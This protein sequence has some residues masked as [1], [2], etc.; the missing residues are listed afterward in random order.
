MARI[1]D[2]SLVRSFIE[3][4]I[5]DAVWDHSTSSKNRKPKPTA[6]RPEPR[7]GMAF[8]P[9]FESNSLPGLPC[10]RAANSVMR[11]VLDAFRMRRT[12]MCALRMA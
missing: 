5:D 7:P 1:N 4:G 10:H 6:S 11:R 3:L 9:R 8:Y 2:N 12:W